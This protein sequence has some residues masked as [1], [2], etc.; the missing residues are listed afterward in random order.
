MNSPDDRTLPTSENEQSVLF[1]L[2][3][4]KIPETEMAK[5]LRH[6]KATKGKHV[7]TRF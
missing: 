7:P 4:V 1:S 3:F 5:D 2:A 6:V